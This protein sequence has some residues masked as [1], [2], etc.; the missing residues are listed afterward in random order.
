LYIKVN[1]PQEFKGARKAA[2]NFIAQCELN[3]D[4]SPE[5][6]HS[7]QRNI[8]FLASFLRNSAF[9]WYQALS[10]ELCSGTFTAFKESFFRSYSDGNLGTK[11]VKM[12]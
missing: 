1:S 6:F 9:N 5:L 7:D 3:F 12:L 4:A 10:D 11:A 8:V 2:H